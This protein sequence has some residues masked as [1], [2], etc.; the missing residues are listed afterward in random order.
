MPEAACVAGLGLECRF[1]TAKSQGP[2]V[3]SGAEGNLPAFPF[4]MK[5]E[6]PPPLLWEK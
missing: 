2:C 5:N 6:W 3:A 4:H 1:G